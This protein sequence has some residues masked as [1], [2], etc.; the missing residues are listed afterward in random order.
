M[1]VFNNFCW[2]SLNLVTL[3]LQLPWCTCIQLAQKFNRF[4]STN[5]HVREIN[6]DKSHG[7]RRWRQP[8][9]ARSPTAKSQRNYQRSRHWTGWIHILNSVCLLWTFCLSWIHM[10]PM[11]PML[12]GA[13]REGGLATAPNSGMFSFFLLAMKMLN[14]VFGVR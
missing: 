2:F 5:S 12:P 8:L 13:K 14:F 11:D 7:N 9:Y 4:L 10:D 3:V 6:M 1:C